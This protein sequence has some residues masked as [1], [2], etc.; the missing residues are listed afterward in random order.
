MVRGKKIS[1]FPALVAQW[2]PRNAPLLPENVSAGSQKRLWWRCAQGH[3]W[4][5]TPNARTNR[6]RDSGGISECKACM[7]RTTDIWSWDHIISVAQEVVRQEGHLPS[8][9]WFQAHQYASL[10]Q[11]IYLHEKRWED[12]QTAVNS[13]EASGTLPS[14]SGLRWSSHPEASVSN[15]LFARGVQHERGHKYPL[16]F[17][18]QSGRGYGYYDLAFFDRKGRCI[19][20]EVWGDKPMGHDEEEYAQ[21][22]AEKERFNSGRKTFVGIHHLDCFTD[23]SLTKILEPFIGTIAPFKFIEPHDPQ[24]ESSHWT[25]ADGTIDQC[26]TLAASQP[27]GKFPPEDWL[28]KRGRWA[29]REG[30]AYNTLACYVGK[31]VGGVRKLRDLIDQ[32][33]NSTQQWTRE[34]ALAELRAWYIEYGRSPGAVRADYQRKKNSLPVSEFKRA[35]RILAAVDKYA[36]GMCKAAT[37]LGFSIRA[38]S[39]Q[40]DG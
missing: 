31:W 10:V 25:F 19:D 22:R 36:G 33:H 8:A 24:I 39:K 5:A 11:A 29:D 21:R 32:S 16:D 6:L 40:A 3:E 13:F 12:L 34:L 23:A 37:E 35:A 18:E 38:S 2:H 15:F 27:D 4:D 20:V 7:P 28:R 17:A 9:G 30:P 14:R 1:D 26:R